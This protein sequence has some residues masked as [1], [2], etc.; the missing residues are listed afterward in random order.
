MLNKRLIRTNDTGGGV[1]FTSITYLRDENVGYYTQSYYAVSDF[2]YNPTDGLIY[3]VS[4]SGV[5]YWLLS[6]TDISADTVTVIVSGTSPYRKFNGIYVKGNTLYIQEGLDDNVYNY[7]VGGSRG[8]SFISA[9]YSSKMSYNVNLDEVL[10]RMYDPADG[11]STLIN[12]YNGTTGAYK[13]GISVSPAL[14]TLESFAWVNTGGDGHIFAVDNTNK[15]VKQL[16][17]DGTDTGLSL[18]ISSYE[19]DGRSFDAMA[20]IPTTNELIIS[21]NSN[22]QAP[23]NMARVF[24]LS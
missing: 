6:K 21:T 5:G 3:S 20:F 9:S 4:R 13:R 19:R 18:D 1:A 8:S 16:N 22:V 11:T 14:T 15:V 7:T 10:I 2:A 24:Q 23:R 17:Y 12:V